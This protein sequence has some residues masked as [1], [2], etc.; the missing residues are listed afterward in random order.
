[1]VRDKKT[2]IIFLVIHVH[3]FSNVIQNILHAK[4]VAFDFVISLFIPR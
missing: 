2:F 1:M 4:I 3:V